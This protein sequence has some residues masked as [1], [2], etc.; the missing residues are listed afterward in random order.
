MRP[1]PAAEQRRR[2]VHRRD[3]G[4]RAAGTRSTRTRA[5]W[6]DYDNDGWL[7]L[8]V[9]CETAAQ[10]A[11]PQP[12]RRHVRGGGRAG[13]ACRRRA[14][15]LQGARLDRLRQR[16]LPRPVR[17]QPRPARAQLFHNN[18]NGTFTDVTTADG[19]RRART[20][21]S[22]AG[23]ATTTTTAGSTSSPPATTARSTDVVHGLLGRAARPARPTGCTATWGA[24]ASRT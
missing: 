15:M 5:A 4:G 6:A 2:H 1:T 17:Q 22:P 20:T 16:R 19:H 7:D 3:R 14:A 18:R 23:R 9:C 10:P 21:A 8:F 13:R 24:R 11:V 12:G